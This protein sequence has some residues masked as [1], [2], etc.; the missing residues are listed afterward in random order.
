MDSQSILSSGNKLGLLEIVPYLNVLSQKTDR[1]V[2]IHFHLSKLLP[3]DHHAFQTLEIFS[4][5]KQ[6]FTPLSGKA[7]ILKNDDLVY[8]SFNNSII[9][10]ERCLSQFRR[11]LSAD[12]F[13]SQKLKPESF[14]TFHSLNYKFS[15]FRTIIHEI[16]QSDIYEN[17]GIFSTGS[18][19]AYKVPLLIAGINLETLSFI[20]NSIKTA[21]ISIFLKREPI[22]SFDATFKPT[23]HSYHYYISLDAL[24]GYLKVN[25]PISTNIWLFR[26]I[27]FYLDKQIITGLLGFIAQKNVP[28]INVNLNLRTL[29]TT[30]FQNFINHYDAS[31]ELTFDIDVIDF[32]AHPEAFEFAVRMLHE[33]GCRVGLSGLTLHHTTYLNF[34]NLPLDSFK[35]IWESDFINNI[36]QLKNTVDLV[37]K[38]KF[39]LTRCDSEIAVQT[40]LLSNIHFFHGRGLGSFLEAPVSLPNPS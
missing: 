22:V 6:V 15:E 5:L 24:Q 12:S 8:I 25:E 28:A 4:V 14:Y 2:A 20:E 13:I 32:M 11:M 19:N 30:T 7:F 34:N 39:V 27:G 1:G 18:E 33:K 26:Q 17:Q 16:E 23:I 37:G 9:Q 21:D 36:G 10:L 40:G 31:K 35:F 38:D 3:Y 29:V